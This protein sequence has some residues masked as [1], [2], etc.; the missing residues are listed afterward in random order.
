MLPRVS[1]SSKNLVPSYGVQVG[2]KHPNNLVPQE[3]DWT[4][5]IQSEGFHGVQVGLKHPNN[6]FH[7]RKV[8]LTSSNLKVFM[9][10][11]FSCSMMLRPVQHFYLLQKALIGS[12]LEMLHNK[13]T[14]PEETRDS[15][16][17]IVP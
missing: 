7:R 17:E 13:F 12:I 16:F 6:L 5:I 3:E 9:E 15:N 2:L 14:N 10:L 8:G 1:A 11:S 4:Y